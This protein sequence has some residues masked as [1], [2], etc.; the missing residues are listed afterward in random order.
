MSLNKVLQRVF[1][2][3]FDF[4]CFANF[5]F[6]DYKVLHKEIFIYRYSI[7]RFSIGCHYHYAQYKEEE[8][9]A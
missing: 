8:K 6:K 9:E 5:V 2:L 4:M 3:C 7:H 1:F